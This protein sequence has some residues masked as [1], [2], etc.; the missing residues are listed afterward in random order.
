M[1][2]NVKETI[3]DQPLLP[4]IYLCYASQGQEESKLTPSPGHCNPI[5]TFRWIRLANVVSMADWLV[6][7]DGKPSLTLII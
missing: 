7:I 3:L 2:A 5:A 1:F 4:S 6:C